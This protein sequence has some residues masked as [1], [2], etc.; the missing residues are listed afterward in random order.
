LSYTPTD[1]D[2]FIAARNGHLLQTWAWGE[3]KAAFGWTPHRLQVD[4]TAAQILFKR[5]PL[6]FTVAYIPKGPVIDWD[7]SQQCRKLLDAVH[8]EAKQRRA[9]FLKIEPDVEHENVEMAERLIDMGFVSADTIQPQTSLT[10]E[11]SGDED[12]ILAAMKQKTRYNIRLATKKGVTVRQGNADDVKIFHDLSLTTSDRD[13]FGVHS[14]AYYQACFN[15][16]APHRCALFIAEFEGEPIAALMAF[17]QGQDAYYFYGASANQYRNLMPTYLIQ[18]AAIQWAKEQGCTRYDL[19]GVPDAD[20][21]TLETEFKNRND[22]LWGVYRFK[23]GFGGK[24][25]QTIGAF[26]YVYNPLLYKF[27]KMRRGA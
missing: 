17:C 5:L 11:I 4:D 18:W 12:S 25:V 24:Y 16:F 19:W 10:I 9:V 7:N 15:L 26:D 27:Y 2:N 14:L 6:G 22:G 8:A 3:L 13:G 23:R 21:K 20:P 1:W